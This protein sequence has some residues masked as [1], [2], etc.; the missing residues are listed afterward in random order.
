MKRNGIIAIDFD[1]TI[2]THQY[3]HI[4]RELPGAI[5][6]IKTLQ[7]N[8]FKV[9]LYTMRDGEQLE[10][11]LEFL[12]SRGIELPGNASPAQFS[13]SPK[14]YATLYIDDAAIGTPLC[15]NH[16]SGSFINA[17]CLNVD[18][19]KVAQILYKRNLLTEEQLKDIIA[20]IHKTYR[21]ETESYKPCE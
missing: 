10:E 14:Q 15:L 20:D 7:A 6:T 2:V 4:G 1:G 16:G 21:N 5:N 18:W 11:A 9:F 17:V 12:E 13:T 3:P 8:G 19:M